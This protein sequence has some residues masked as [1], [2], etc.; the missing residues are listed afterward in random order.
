MAVRVLL[1]DD[2]ILFRNAL[3][4]LLATWEDLEVVGEVGDGETALQ[5][6]QQLRPDVVV[7]DM[8]LPG[9][10]GIETTRQLRQNHPGTAVLM[11]SGFAD[12]PTRQAAARA[13]ATKVLDKGRLGSLLPEIKAAAQ[14]VAAAG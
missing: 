2:Q 12:E 4:A 9:I 10:D 3:S 5:M 6:V 14:T 1:V 7:L 8:R 13:G 11:L